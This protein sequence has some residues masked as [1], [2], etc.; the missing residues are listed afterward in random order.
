MTFPSYDIF[1][2]FVYFLMEKTP[3][4]PDQSETSFYSNALS[5]CEMYFI[6]DK[7]PN[8]MRFTCVMDYPRIV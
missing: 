2:S 1:V 4:F 7:D 8:W 6:S 3:F 5:L